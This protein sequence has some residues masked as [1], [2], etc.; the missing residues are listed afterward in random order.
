MKKTTSFFLLLALLLPVVCG[1]AVYAAEN[2]MTE[3]TLP[4]SASPTPDVDAL[5]KAIPSG[6][7]KTSDLGDYTVVYPSYYAEAD[8][9]MTEVG[10][11]CRTLSEMSGKDVKAAPDTEEINGKSIVFASTRALPAYDELLD[12]LP[13]RLDYFIAAD[14]SGNIVLGG[15]DYYGDMRAAYDFINNTLGYNDL[16]GVWSDPK[17]EISGV[18]PVLFSE[19]EF[20]IL[21]GNFYKIPFTDPKAV[22][23]MVRCG[24]N[25]T[26]NFTIS[27]YETEEQLRDYCLWCCRF[28]L[29]VLLTQ[30]I[31]VKE[32]TYAEYPNL[33]A[34]EDNPI[35]WGVYIVDEP[36]YPQRISLS[37]FVDEWKEKFKDKG[38]KTYV[39]DCIIGTKYYSCI[40]NTFEN[41]DVLGIDYYFEG[42]IRPQGEPQYGQL[43]LNNCESLNAWEKIYNEAK[44]N[45]KEFWSYI[46]AFEL[47]RYNAAKMIP[48]SMFINLCYGPDGIAYFNYQTHLITNDTLEPTDAWYVSQKANETIMPI[49]QLLRSEYDHVGVHS[50]N[51]RKDDYFMYLE[52]DYPYFGEEYGTFDY[53]DDRS[54]YFFGLF[55]KKDGTG[56]AF[57]MVN[58][59]QLDNN[60]VENTT[61]KTVKFKPVGDQTLTFTRNGVPFDCS[62]DADGSYS[63]D[64]GNGCAVFVTID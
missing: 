62:P 29:P 21:A 37:L 27:C 58:C 9:Q 14:E 38:W 13:S 15:Q 17:E 1:C 59:S 50:E 19:P 4:V 41:V 35:I 47:D 43:P 45:G 24:F 23:D 3:D 22:R 34:Y 26:L 18:T 30:R 7:V 12:A 25:M 54:P 31:R 52:S 40:G 44:R 46:R 55:E 60:S 64:C 36:D 2:A 61:G 11:L 57:L 63:F 48:W 20:K 10:L 6:S 32:T 39:N 16:D 42:G 5:A 51:A 8:W 49:G 33:A 53:G 56:K 28:G